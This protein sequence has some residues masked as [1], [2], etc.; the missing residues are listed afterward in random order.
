MSNSSPAECARQILEAV[1]LV[2]HAIRQEMRSRRSSDLSVPLFRILVFLNRNTGASLSDI[3]ERMGLTLPSVSKMVDGLVSRQ[4]VTR[5]P[6]RIDRRR[7]TLALTTA[8]RTVMEAASAFTQTRLAE[9]LAALSEPERSSVH[10][11]MTA[12]GAIFGPRKDS[13]TPE[14]K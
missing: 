11:A 1:P 8:G 3:A 5:R 2:M 4:L 12:L 14:G 10:Q 6:D 7:V 9:R 13:K